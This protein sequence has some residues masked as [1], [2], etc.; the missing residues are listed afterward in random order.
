MTDES[1]EAGEERLHASAIVDPVRRRSRPSRAGAVG[2]VRRAG[3]VVQGKVHGP[4]TVG[5]FWACRTGCVA[6]RRV[7]SFSSNRLEK[8][9]GL[10]AREP[11]ARGNGPRLPDPGA[12]R[13]ATLDVH[14]VPEHN[15]HLASGNALGK[16]L[17]CNSSNRSKGTQLQ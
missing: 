7:H 16:G 17:A 1:A 3:L 14:L 5:H 6:R 11:G 12:C 8:L 9:A 4:A 2:R 13:H 15:L 10:L